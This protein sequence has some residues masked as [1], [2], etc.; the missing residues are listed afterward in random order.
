VIA[1]DALNALPDA[2]FVATLAGIFEHSPWIPE[3]ARSRRPFAA[4]LAL[5]DA[6]RDVV[7]VATP[8][9][10]LGLIRAHPKLG[11]RGRAR[12]EL[13]AASAR[14]QTRAG[15]AALSDEEFAQLQKLNAAYLEKFDFPFILAVKGHD[16]ASILAN[17]GRRLASAPPEEQRTALHQIGRIAGFRLADL[18][19]SDPRAELSA[20]R[21]RLLALPVSPT[22]REESR[23]DRVREWLLAAGFDVAAGAAGEIHARRQLGEPSSGADGAPVIRPP[24]D[25]VPAAT[26]CEA[27]LGYLAGIAVLQALRPS[28]G[29]IARGELVI[30]VSAA[31]LADAALAA[32]DTDIARGLRQVEHVLRTPA[33]PAGVTIAH[34]LQP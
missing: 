22:P 9:E 7:A 28:G 24:M 34:Q 15:L 33:G 6:M 2:G 10:Q 16:P 8:E 19:V 23:A 4:R 1:L 26:R 18:V 20:M 3:R 21:E 14:E 5:L 32:A 12:A 17:I 30:T 27:P 11:A 29:A 13:T 25:G 31:D